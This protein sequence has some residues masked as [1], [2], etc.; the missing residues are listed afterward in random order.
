MGLFLVAFA[1][2]SGSKALD[3]ALLIAYAGACLCI[4]L[5][6]SDLHL[7]GIKSRHLGAAIFSVANICFF[8]QVITT[9]REG[10]LILLWRSQ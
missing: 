8:T 10:L 4:V 6:S 9:G 7:G 1:T 3:N 2:S 5:G